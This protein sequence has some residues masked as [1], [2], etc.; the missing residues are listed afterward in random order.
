MIINAPHPSIQNYQGLHLFHAN[1]SSCSQRVRLALAEKGIDWWESHHIDLSKDQHVTGDFH[2]INPKAQVPVLIHD[3]VVH[4]ESADIIQYLDLV[5]PG[6]PL[7]PK[8][9]NAL[10]LVEKWVALSDEVQ[11]ALK[12][13]S[14]EFIFKPKARKSK[15]QLEAYE[16]LERDNP[17]LVDFHRRFSSSSG[18]PREEVQSAVTKI[19][20]ALRELDRAL[21]EN[22][23]IGG[24]EFSAA[25]I[26]WM[27]NIHRF[28]LGRL[29]MNN[30]RHLMRWFA[31]AQ[32]RPS[33]QAA[34]VAWEPWYFRV[35]A[36]FTYAAQRI[37]GSSVDRYVK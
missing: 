17:Y 20:G 4:I 26:P 24:K 19:M 25:D 30:F 15:N 28:S 36:R 37:F 7:F 11:S 6:Q 27:V 9:R 16:K 12:V 10:S 2:L 29:P 3:G 13:F 33:Y 5:F 1:L 23:W 8:S 31:Q 35:F 32:K 14:F 34:L 21:A 18:L 22:E